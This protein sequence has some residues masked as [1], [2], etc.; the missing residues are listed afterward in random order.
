MMRKRSSMLFSLLVV[1]I[2]FLLLGTGSIRAD[3]RHDRD[4]GRVKGPVQLLKTI[5]VPVSAA[6]S[7][8]GALYSF[9]ISFVDPATQTYYLADRSNKAGD[10]VNANADRPDSE[11]LVPHPGEVAGC[12][13]Q[14]RNIWRFQVQDKSPLNPSVGPRTNVPTHR[15]GASDRDVWRRGGDPTSGKRIGMTG[16]ESAGSTPRTGAG[17][18]TII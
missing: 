13:G 12:R 1:T 14:P 15:V 7:T 11:H 2:P 10:V 17:T 6:N 16:E 9:D 4:D 18:C 3:D 8:A 5:R